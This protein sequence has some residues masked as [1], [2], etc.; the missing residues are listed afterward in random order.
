M[1]VNSSVI[2]DDKSVSQIVQEFK[3]DQ[4]SDDEA[5]IEQLR[6]NVQKLA[7]T[8]SMTKLEQPNDMS[9]VSAKLSEEEISK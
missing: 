7:F 4:E 2:S 1:H 8:D 6:A 3:T 5:Q 9:F